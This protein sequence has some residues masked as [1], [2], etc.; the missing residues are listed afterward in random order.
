LWH[1]IISEKSRS[2]S[3]L[4]IWPFNDGFVCLL[5]VERFIAVSGISTIIVPLVMRCILVVGSSFSISAVGVGRF[6]GYPFMKALNG[7]GIVR[8]GVSVLRVGRLLRASQFFSAML[9]WSVPFDDS[10]VRSWSMSLRQ[11]MCL[12]MYSVMM[13]RWSFGVEIRPK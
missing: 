4:H 10:S 5:T 6:I 11:L 1:C 13:S 8:V 3:S 2:G 7:R 9:V 12:S